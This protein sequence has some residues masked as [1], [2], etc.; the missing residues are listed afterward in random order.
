MSE[1]AHRTPRGSKALR[2][3]CAPSTTCR[4]TSHVGEIHAVIGPNGAGKSTL[5]NLLSGDLKPT[6]G[7]IV[8]G[9]P[10]R[11]RLGAGPA[12]PARHRPL[13]P[14]DHDLPATS[15]SSRTCGSPRRRMRRRRLRMFGA[16]WRDAAVCASAP[17]RRWQRS[18]SAARARRPRRRAQPRR[19]APARDR[20]GARD[21]PEDRAARRAARRHGRSGVARAW[22]TLIALA[23]QRAGRCCWSSTTWTRCSRSP[24]A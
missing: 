4:S 7:T 15:R 1:L 3:A 14:E 21:R 20:H 24:T 22:S 12:R 11:D 23:A 6:G 19:A 17:R 8:L 18:G 5:V 10:R 13:V 16:R 2:R 9:E